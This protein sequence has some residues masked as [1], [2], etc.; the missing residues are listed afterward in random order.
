MNIAD[1]TEIEIPIV[2]N[3]T[4]TSLHEFLCSCTEPEDD[5]T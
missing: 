4:F 2:N 1:V 5:L 3:I